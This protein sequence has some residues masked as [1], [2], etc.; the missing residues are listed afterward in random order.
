VIASTL[1]LRDTRTKDPYLYCKVSQSYV[2]DEDACTDYIWRATLT[3][4]FDWIPAS[5][6]ANGIRGLEEELVNSLSKYLMN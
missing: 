2:F 5:P 6:S 3:R 1:D 4:H